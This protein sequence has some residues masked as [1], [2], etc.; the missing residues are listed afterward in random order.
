MYLTALSLSTKLNF[1][2]IKGELLLVFPCH[3][4]MR[5]DTAHITKVANKRLSRWDS[6]KCLKGALKTMTFPVQHL[7]MISNGWYLTQWMISNTRYL[8]GMISNNQNLM[9]LKP[10]V[11]WIHTWEQHRLFWEGGTPALGSQSALTTASAGP[12]LSKI[13]GVS[14]TGGG[15]VK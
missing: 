11:S 15:T 6:Q 3:L 1:K 10:S 5:N 9:E 2:M 14:V 13:I 7:L 12:A 8:K 4:R